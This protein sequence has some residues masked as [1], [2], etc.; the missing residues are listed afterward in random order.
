M[1]YWASIKLQ[2]DSAKK[3]KNSK[4]WSKSIQKKP[5]CFHHTRLE[6]KG[7]YTIHRGTYLKSPFSQPFILNSFVF[8]I[9]LMYDLYYC[10]ALLLKR[11]TVGM[12]SVC[13]YN[14]V[15]THA[16]KSFSYCF[17]SNSNL[18]PECIVV[19]CQLT[20]CLHHLA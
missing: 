14:T 3:K 18:H 4:E 7:S 20:S 15:W 5:Q 8:D 1:Y 16:V 17:D 6:A 13:F 2:Q 9:F 11:L 19:C 12:Q 10:R